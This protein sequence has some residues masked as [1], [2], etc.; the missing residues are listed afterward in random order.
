MK[1]WENVWEKDNKYLDLMVRRANGKEPI[2]E[3]TKQLIRLAK[4]NYKKGQSFLDVT[5][6]TGHYLYAFRKMLDK[7]IIYFGVD[8]NRRYVDAAIKIFGKDYFAVGDVNA[9]P[10]RD[11]SFDVVFCF[12]TL[13][14]LP[15]IFTPLAQL[16]RVSKDYVYI[17]TLI[18]E[19]QYYIKEH[20]DDGVVYHNIHTFK[21]IKQFARDSGFSAKLIPDE[22][23]A[24]VFSKSHKGDTQVIDGKQVIG[25]IIYS[26]AIIMFRRMR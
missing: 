14:N 16:M 24:S 26:W 8:N 13:Q 15:D 18:G 6:S 17:R 21:Q 10:F 19:S 12:N 25:N 3:C 5:C 22:Y 1:E 9:L 2:M 4:P 7:N 11:R 23:D 20:V